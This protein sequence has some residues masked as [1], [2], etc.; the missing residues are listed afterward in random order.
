MAHNSDV[1]S[2]TT[3]ANKDKQPI[4]S[5]E[6]ETDCEEFWTDFDEFLFDNSS[7]TM[8]MMSNNEPTTSGVNELTSARWDADL[9]SRM[10]TPENKSEGKSPQAICSIESRN[11]KTIKTKGSK[12]KIVEPSEEPSAVIRINDDEIKAFPQKLATAFNS[13]RLTTMDK[14]IDK[15]FISDASL[16]TPYL[17]H[18]LVGNHH[19]KQLFSS[20]LVDRPDAIHTI[21][22]AKIVVE[23]S[24]CERYLAVKLEFQA[25]KC[26]AVETVE[27]LR[28]IFNPE[29]LMEQVGHEA[30]EKALRLFDDTKTPYRAVGDT[31]FR[32]HLN[33]DNRITHCAMTRKFKS[34]KACHYLRDTGSSH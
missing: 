4:R 8:I 34:A 7:S 9:N 29:M 13:G 10:S 20:I 6:G 31:W 2:F 21:K 1:I 16:R 26:F 15:Y 24:T 32:Y 19:F 28:E 14:L 25:T 27:K 3:N 23:S 30:I 17:A 22:Y 12:C 5:D 18:D 11:D 33:S